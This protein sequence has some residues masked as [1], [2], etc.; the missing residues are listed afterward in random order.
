MRTNMVKECSALVKSRNLLNV[1]LFICKYFQ[2][3]CIK[4]EN[5]LKVQQMCQL[6]WYLDLGMKKNTY[7]ENNCLYSKQNLEKIFVLRT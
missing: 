2:V 1:S 5:L 3:Y 6:R 4:I 7:Y